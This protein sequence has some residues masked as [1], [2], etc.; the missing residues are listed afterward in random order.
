MRE[1]PRW[2]EL[3]LRRAQSPSPVASFIGLT[4]VRHVRRV[5]QAGE[6][7]HLVRGG[8]LA[9]LRLCP[10]PL[11]KWHDQVIVVPAAMSRG[12]E[13]TLGGGSFHTSGPLAE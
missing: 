2:A 3:R 4:L 7:V 5:E 6:D 13:N 9:K 11:L 10:V 1:V 8:G 12:G